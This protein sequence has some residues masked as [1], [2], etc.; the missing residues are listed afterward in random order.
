ML[1]G[2]FFLFKGW[3]LCFQKLSATFTAGTFSNSITKLS[4]MNDKMESYPMKPALTQ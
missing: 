3:E 2:S 1:S 4:E